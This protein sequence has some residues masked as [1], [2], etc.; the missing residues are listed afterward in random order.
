[1]DTGTILLIDGSAERRRLLRSALERRGYVIAGEAGTV[2]EVIDAVATCDAVP[3]TVLVGSE[4]GGRLAS[5]IASLVKRMWP[6]ATVI[7]E[8]SR[9]QP[10]LRAA[11]A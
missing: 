6:K 10:L 9:T 3:A 2:P 8:A 11:G 4:V 1:M 5:P 7:Q